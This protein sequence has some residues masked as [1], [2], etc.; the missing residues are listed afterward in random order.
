MKD[1]FHLDSDEEARHLVGICDANI[2]RI[3]EL[4]NATVHVR[5]STVTVEGSTEVVR[6]GRQF[7]KYLL[8]ESKRGHRIEDMLV[9]QSIIDK[10]THI[11]SVE[12]VSF[13]HN[14]RTIG[15]RT[16]G[17]SK[18]LSAVQDKD[19]VFC[20]GP[21]GTGKTYLAMALA[22]EF[23][24]QQKVERIIL[25]RPA[26]ES[27]EHLGFLPGDLNAKINPYL[28]PLLDA[29]HEMMSHEEIEEKIQR[30]VIE[31]VPLAYMRGRTLNDSFII[32][33]E[34]QNSTPLQ[35]KM[36]L[37]RLGFGSRMVV[38]GDVTQSDIPQDKQ[39]GLMEAQSILKYVA[40]IQ[41]I[42]LT[43][44]DVVRHALVRDILK[45][46]EKKTTKKTKK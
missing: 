10:E 38:T 3:E 7:I 40:G 15:P 1:S 22:I 13:R 5:D 29:L 46:Y 34:A 18:Y 11:Q 16:K 20:I 36:F 28:R 23:L 2:R 4:T 43:D 9:N 19:V 25:S 44:Q 30:G 31:I 27:G 21:A 8:K 41:F 12:T 42:H 26:V 35:M 24:K 45:A 37:T 17:Q 14:G 33:D 39:S 32:L 6:E